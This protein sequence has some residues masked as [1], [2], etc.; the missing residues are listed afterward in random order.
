[1]TSIIMDNNHESDGPKFLAMIFLGIGSFISGL[2]PI[3]IS[4]ES[5]RRFPLL[6]SVLLCFGAGVLLATALVHMLPDV[7]THIH[8]S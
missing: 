8:I 7:S 4:Q 2:L 5:R 3:A 6:I 1:M